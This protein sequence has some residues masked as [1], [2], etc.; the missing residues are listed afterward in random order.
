MAAQGGGLLAAQG[1][2]QLGERRDAGERKPVLVGVGDAGLLLDGVGEIGEREA[3]GFEL[4]LGDA[5][6]EGHR[7]E[8][9]AAGAF[10]V[11][12]REPD[13]VADLVIV[14]AFDDGGDE[15]DLEAGLA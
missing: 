9:D 3:L 10:D 4:V 1:A 13:D 6:G 7:L 15:D 12:Q 14:Q 5:A 8:A 2:E 11:L